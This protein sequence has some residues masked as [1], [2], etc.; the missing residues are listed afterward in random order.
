[1]GCICSFLHDLFRHQMGRWHSFAAGNFQC[2][3]DVQQRGQDS[4]GHRCYLQFV[5]VTVP[6]RTLA[7]SKCKLTWSQASLWQHELHLCFC[8]AGSFELD[9]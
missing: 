3:S 1:M 8:F 2:L 9:L 5:P 4:L 7:L 6:C